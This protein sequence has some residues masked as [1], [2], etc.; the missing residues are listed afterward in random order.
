MTLWMPRK[1]PLY[2]PMLST[3]GG[4]SARGFNP[5]GGAPDP[6]VP[7]NPISAMWFFGTT[8]PN[9]SE[10]ENIRSNFDAANTDL[11]FPSGSTFDC[12]AGGADLDQPTEANGNTYSFNTNPGTW[13]ANYDS[14]STG[15]GSSTNDYAMGAA[16]SMYNGGKGVGVHMF[17]TGSYQESE[18]Y[19]S[20]TY[21]IPTSAKIG[22]GSGYSSSGSTSVN[23]SSIEQPFLNNLA[24]VAR[25]SSQHYPTNGLSTYNSA[26][27]YGTG[28]DGS[29]YLVTAKNGVSGGVGRLIAS[30]HPTYTGSGTDRW[31]SI[32]T[33]YASLDSGAQ[34]MLK[35]AVQILYWLA[36]E[37][38]DI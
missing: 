32:N 30:S 13:T 1:K 21:N 2:A 35:H 3:F 25:G 38:D 5:A 8:A 37:M 34:N 29:G 27:G 12:Y 23:T 31:N 18:V 33:A 24:S 22:M 28:F 11:G 9:S 16:K 14:M 7:Q 26:T 20:G 10:L 19:G 15:N 6:L 36:G 17:I 4:G